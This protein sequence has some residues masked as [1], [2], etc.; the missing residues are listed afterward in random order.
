MDLYRRTRVCTGRDPKSLECPGLPS[1]RDVAEM[2]TCAPD[3]W[4]L[5]PLSL[6]FTFF[7]P[8]SSVFSGSRRSTREDNGVNM[9]KIYFMHI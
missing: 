6:L 8:S 3:R 7:A 4:A 5:L 2:D 9:I 1:P